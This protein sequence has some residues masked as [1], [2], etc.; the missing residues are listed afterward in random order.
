MQG[1]HLVVQSAL[2]TAEPFL[3]CVPAPTGSRV[4][5]TLTLTRPERGPGQAGMPPPRVVYRS[6]LSGVANRQGRMC[7]VLPQHYLPTTAIRGTLTV[8][9]LGRPPLHTMVTLRRAL[10]SAQ[11]P[12]PISGVAAV[13]R[14]AAPVVPAVPPGW[15]QVS[16]IARRIRP[17]VLTLQVGTTHQLTVYFSS[18]TPL[19][20]RFGRTLFVA[21]IAAGQRLV[22][23]G[24]AQGSRALYARQIRDL[25]VR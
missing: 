21:D 9:I 12:P 4:R 15:V 8:S 3:V 23:V 7:G 10:T 24:I 5:A 17:T 2:S 22:V 6:T 14:P 19:V 1:A 20:A 13:G 25:D 18:V 16:G 11:R